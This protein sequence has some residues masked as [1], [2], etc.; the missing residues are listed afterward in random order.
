MGLVLA[1]VSAICYGTASVFQAIAARR[2]PA[3]G[4][5]DARSVAKVFLQWPYVIGLALDGLGFV[6]QFIA[7]RTLPIFL[8]Q[9]A[10][11]ASL[12]VT[13]IV[14]VPVLKLRLGALQWGAVAGVCVG[15]ALLGISAGH[16]NA[17]RPSFAFRIGLTISVPVLAVIGLV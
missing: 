8:V 7:L 6:F 13:A 10:L 3:A 11:A 4:S 9:S 12:A 14:A 1:I 15:L 17:D 5:V 16:E 2:A